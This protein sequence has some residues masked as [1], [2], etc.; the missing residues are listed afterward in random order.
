MQSYA[1]LF[2]SSCVCRFYIFSL[3]CSYHCNRTQKYGICVLEYTGY[4]GPYGTHMYHSA[5]TCNAWNVLMPHPPLLRPPQGS[6]PSG[7]ERD[8]FQG[9]TR[10]SQS[11][12]PGPT[13]QVDPTFCTQIWQ[14]DS[15][16]DNFVFWFIISIFR[17]A[18]RPSI[19]PCRCVLSQLFP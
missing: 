6:H 3:L 19:L 10:L 15:V 1:G 8:S 18:E 17:F 7:S 5:R 16:C 2:L 11:A 14:R 4:M 12:P 9:K 13:F